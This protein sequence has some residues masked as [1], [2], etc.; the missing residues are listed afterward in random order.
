MKIPATI[1]EQIDL[2]RELEISYKTLHPTAILCDNQSGRNIRIPFSSV[3]NKYKDFL[4]SSIIEIEL[5]EEL[6]NR[7][8]YKPKMVS[9]DLYKTP[10]LWNDVLI[11]NGAISTYDFTPVSLKVYDPSLLKDIL[12]EIIVLENMYE[13]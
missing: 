6:Q 1:P 5:D 2:I 9:Y 10:E 13:S 4:A 8:C 11:L 3:T 12:N 7:Y